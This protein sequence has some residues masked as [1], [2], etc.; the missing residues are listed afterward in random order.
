M[1]FL[2]VYSRIHHAC[3]VGCRQ[4]KLRF[5]TAPVVPLTLWRILSPRCKQFNKKRPSCDGLFLLNLVGA[6]GFEPSTP[7]SQT[8]Y[9]TRLSYAPKQTTV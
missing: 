7:W 8:K 9:S 4:Q 6:K 2:I 1:I 3:L 5:Q